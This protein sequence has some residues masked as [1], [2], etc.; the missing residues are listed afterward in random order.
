MNFYQLLLPTFPCPGRVLVASSSM[1]SSPRSGSRAYPGSFQVTT[2]VKV[3]DHM[4]FGAHP[5]RMEPLFPI[6]HWLSHLQALLVYRKPD[7]HKTRHSG[8]ASFQCKTPGEPNVGFGTLVS[9][10]ECLQFWLSFC[11]WFIYLWL[12]VLTI[13]CPCPSYP[14]H[15]GSYFISSAVEKSFLP[16]SSFS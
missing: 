7:M 12:W 5:L 16:V 10:R 13:L 2:T 3:L 11:S 6:A 4:R 15:W 14:S 8:C 9:Q 1:E